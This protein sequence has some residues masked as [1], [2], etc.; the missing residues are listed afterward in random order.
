MRR[1]VPLNAIRVFEVAARLGSFAGAAR[2]LNV[3]NGAVSRQIALL[4]DW[5]GVPLFLRLNRQVSLTEEGRTLLNEV[6]AALDRIEIA[7]A[8][9]AQ[10]RK[11]L[12]LSVNATPTLTMHWLIPRLSKFNRLHP[13][14][15]VRLSAS[16]GAVDFAAGGYDIA[17]RRISDA[18]AG[19]QASPI[20]PGMQFP[21]CS[22]ALVRELNLH[23]PRDLSRAN[24]LHSETSPQSWPRWLEI[25]GEKG[26]VAAGSLRFEQM[27]FTVQ[28]ALNGLGVA[29]APAIMLIDDLTT[30][31]LTIPFPSTPLPGHPYRLVSP[32]LASGAGASG[33]EHAVA[34]FSEWI[35]AEGELS[36]SALTEIVATP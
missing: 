32:P 22:P 12:T 10:R 13:G 23:T 14:I 34:Q 36:A 35:I 30:N 25:S 17:I 4:E 3:T 9:V 7:T 6:S 16:L 18:P 29:M 19:L 26:L 28:A 33:K 15:E 11:A 21:V 31:R 8:A 2:E 1:A 20:L 24:L 5:L 27:Y